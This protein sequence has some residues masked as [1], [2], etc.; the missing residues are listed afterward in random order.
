MWF[1]N[2]NAYQVKNLQITPEQ[3][4]EKIAIHSFV[5]CRPDEE[6]Q[7]GWVSP[8]GDRNDVLVH[9]A[10]GAMIFCMKTEEKKVPAAVINEKVNEI[11]E[12]LKEKD[13]T[14]KKVKKD[15]KQRIAE[16]VKQELLPNA[17][18]K[19]DRLMAYIDSKENMLIVNT[20]SQAKAERLISLL[21]AS[22]SED[23]AFTPILVNDNPSVKM[24][25]WL[26]EGTTPSELIVGERCQLKDQEDSGTIR[27]SKHDLDDSK[28]R[29]YLES[30]KVISEME[31]EVQS[32]HKFLINEEFVIKGIKFL[33][34]LKDEARESGADSREAQF[35]ADFAI[36]VGSF[37]ELID[38]L[39]TS[40]GGVAIAEEE[41]EE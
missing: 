33:D 22:L 12:D 29:Q 35:D 17:F 19:I 36:M 7:V 9:G 25:E 34:L 41:Q 37:R 11:I 28:L 21:R 1:K 24:S 16:Q 14:M 31:F 23:V 18:A 27:Y 2:I 10:S 5:P 13:P 4:Q 32:K 26:L 38:Y 15:V 6:S 39:I 40:F 3:L 20:S 30:G 8:F